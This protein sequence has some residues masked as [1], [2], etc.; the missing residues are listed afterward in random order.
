V[1]G[2]HEHVDLVALDE[3]VGVVDGLAR[4]A[5]VVDLEVLHLA[6]AELAALLLHVQLEALL[7][8]VAERGIGAGGR[9]HE[10]DLERRRLGAGADRGE[11]GRGGQGEGGG[12]WE[13]LHPGFSGKG[14]HGSMEDAP[15]STRPARGVCRMR[16]SA[17]KRTRNG[18][19]ACAGAAAAAQV[20]PTEP[21]NEGVP[22]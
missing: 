6:A 3:L 5:L 17:N 7:D 13:L 2:A 22:G 11:G 10:A 4:L 21:E 1:H 12:A 9:Q 18:R 16:G 15:G 8:H 19:R 20:L 14:L